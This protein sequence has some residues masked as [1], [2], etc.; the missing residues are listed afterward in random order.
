MNT[1][2]LRRP[3]DVMICACDDGLVCF[4]YEFTEMWLAKQRGPPRV[5]MSVWNPLAEVRFDPLGYLFLTFL[6]V[7]RSCTWTAKQIVLGFCEILRLPL[8]WS[9][10]CMSFSGMSV[11]KAATETSRTALS[12]SR[13]AKLSGLEGSQCLRWSMINQGI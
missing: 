12:W 10:F 1:G 7:Q 5:C 6:S 13:Q 4:L 3:R 11:P 9:L 2:P 8:M